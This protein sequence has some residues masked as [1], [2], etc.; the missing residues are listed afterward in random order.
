MAVNYKSVK[1]G[2]A[3][4]NNSNFSLMSPNVAGSHQLNESANS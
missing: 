4:I 3:F 1:C 2:R